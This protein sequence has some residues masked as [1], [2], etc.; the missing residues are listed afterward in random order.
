MTAGGSLSAPERPEGLP[1]RP[2]RAP[3]AAGRPWRAV[4][5]VPI[6]VVA[7][8]AGAVTYALVDAIR[9]A[10]VDAGPHRDGIVGV[11]VRGTP[12]VVSL[13]ATFAQD[14]VLVAGS[15][16]AAAMAAGRRLRPADLGL[17]PARPVSAA[18]LVLAGY[19]AF[20]VLAAAW[21]SALHITD[22]ENVP[23]QLGTR[24][25][26]AALV[27]AAFLVCVVA[28]VCEE[29]F[30]R[31]FLF[32][33][34][35]RHGLWAATLVTGLAFG[36]A[37]AASSPIG[38][39]VPLAALGM[40]LCLLYE[41]TGSLYPCI[42]LHALNN[43]IAFGVGDGRGWLVPACLAGSAVAV[44]ALSRGVRRAFPV[45]RPAAF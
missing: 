21:T 42:A 12:P 18:G 10:L 33:A 1:P 9:S 41:R 37:H 22:R 44:T 16:L 25:S 38:F 27:G 43:S 30:F 4:W 3:L 7:V 26:T 20:V 32:G 36:A 13:T 45:N 6:A 8:L 17:R 15:V 39:I 23:V 31:G 2:P 35:R 34:L 24:D 28:P 19:G 29:L 5:A 11:A 14:A 40:I